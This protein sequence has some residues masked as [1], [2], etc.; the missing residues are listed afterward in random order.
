MR[1]VPIVAMQPPGQFGGAFVRGVVGASIGPFTQ[2]CL[3]EALG[4]A[5]G[6]WRMKDDRG[7]ELNSGKETSCGFVVACGHGTIVLEL[8]EEALDELRSQ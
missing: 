2:G 3:D 5:V 8:V 6:F 4:L 7:N 1:P